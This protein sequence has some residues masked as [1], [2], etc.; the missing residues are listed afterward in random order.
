MMCANRN[1]LKHY[2][3]N[4]PMVCAQRLGVQRAAGMN[5]ADISERPFLAPASQNRP[6]PAAPLQRLVRQRPHSGAV[7][8]AGIQSYLSLNSSLRFD[9]ITSSKIWIR[10]EVII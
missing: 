1:G 5:R 2:R 7:G 10:A 6:D 4:T 3:T 8:G 9:M